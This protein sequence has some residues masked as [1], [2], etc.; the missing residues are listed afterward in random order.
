M[1]P[2]RD[3]DGRFGAKRYV[4]RAF[5]A[6]WNL[7]LV[8]GG[9]AAAAL[10]PFPDVALPIIGA[11][12]IGYLTLLTS[13]PNFRTAVDAED[14][15]RAREAGAPAASAADASTTLLALLRT[16]PPE[17][18]RRFEVLRRRCREMLAIASGVRG[19]GAADTRADAVRTPALD[20]LLYLFLKLLVS[21]EG[22]ARFL[23]TTSE[24]ELALRVTDV[25][26]RLATAT[27]AGDERLVSSLT[28][29]V[30][31]AKLRLENYRKSAKDAE[32]V[33]VELD[34]IETKIQALVE[35]SVGR[36]DP[37]F[38]S[39]Q[40]TAAAESMQHTEAAVNQLQSLSGLADELGDAPPILDAGFARDRA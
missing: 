18:V 7:L 33:G 1:R 34:R 23:R 20:R 12:E 28:D 39:A 21:Q 17:S 36:Q 24:S 31:D 14:A 40:V 10:S 15:K 9:A 29:S 22:L 25:E 16:L 38:L 3:P 8:A 32:F 27:T 4:R 19:G 11:L 2:S 13:I 30:A 26:A 37:D 6:P 5:L 35:M